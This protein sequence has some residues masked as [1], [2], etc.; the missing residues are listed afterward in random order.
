MTKIINRVVILISMFCLVSCAKKQIVENTVDMN[1]LKSIAKLSTLECSFNNIA[2]INKEKGTGFFHIGEKERKMFIEYK[3][4][5]KIGIDFNDL[6]YNEKTKTITIPKSI[7]ISI[8]DDTNSYS[9]IISKDGFLNKNQIPDDS[10]K[11]GINKSLSDMEN[12]VKN[13][14]T[15]MSQAQV[16]AKEYVDNYIK[17]LNDSFDRESDIKYVLEE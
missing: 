14:R 15:L 1:A 12:I 6:K 10:I 13:N 17:K 3:G 7:I 16:L 2:K 9:N 8:N 4:T 11:S 5:V